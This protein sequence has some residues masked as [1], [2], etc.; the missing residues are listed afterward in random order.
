MEEKKS[1]FSVGF[2]LGAVIGAGIVLFLNSKKGKDV[3]KLLSDNGLDGILDLLSEDEEKE[4][5]PKKELSQKKILA[6]HIPIEENFV[7]E[8]INVR[9]VRRFFRGA[10]P[11]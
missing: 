6:T 11:L 5:K 10:R 9:P 4:V 1:N 7:K 2:L 3:L 8:E